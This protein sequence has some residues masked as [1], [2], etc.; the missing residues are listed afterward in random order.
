[1]KKDAERLRREAR[2]AWYL[3]HNGS[4]EDK[5][6]LYMREMAAS[7]RYFS[8]LRRQYPDGTD[9]PYSAIINNIHGR[10]HGAKIMKKLMEAR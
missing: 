9:N 7:R 6:R 8:E 2:A 5:P 3:F 1:M 10:M 4:A